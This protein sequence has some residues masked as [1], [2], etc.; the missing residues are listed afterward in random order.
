MSTKECLN[1]KKLEVTYPEFVYNHLLH[2]LVLAMRIW[3]VAVV[4]P[5]PS[6]VAATTRGIDKPREILL[7]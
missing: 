1:A 7:K 2:V 5:S 4:S 3:R 6:Y